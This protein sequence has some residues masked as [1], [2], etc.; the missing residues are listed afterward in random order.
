MNL[1]C[2]RVSGPEILRDR[3]YLSMHDFA[4][5]AIEITRLDF[6]YYSHPTACIDQVRGEIFLKK[7]SRY[8]LLLAPNRHEIAT[9]FASLVFT[10]CLEETPASDLT[11]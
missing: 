2:V 8:L 10:L 6:A 11:F 4:H 5:S 1:E 9:L 3:V 7:M